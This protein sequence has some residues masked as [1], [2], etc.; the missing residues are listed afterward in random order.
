MTW[1][2]ALNGRSK[3]YAAKDSN[4]VKVRY[5]QQMTRDNAVIT[6]PMKTIRSSLFDSFALLTEGGSRI[7]VVSSS[8]FTVI[9]PA[10]WL[11]NDTINRQKITQEYPTVAWS[12]IPQ[13]IRDPDSIVHFKKELRSHRLSL[14]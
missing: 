2:W 7:F 4:Y 14:A 3:R 11:R 12:N 13:S 8:I 6:K 5:S 10:S 9:S 1:K